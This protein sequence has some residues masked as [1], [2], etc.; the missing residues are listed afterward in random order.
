VLQAIETNAQKGINIINLN[1]HGL[2]SGVY[3]VMING[4]NQACNLKFLKE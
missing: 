2:A 1:A 3:F 4:N